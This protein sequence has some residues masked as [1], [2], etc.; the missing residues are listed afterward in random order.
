MLLLQEASGDPWLRWFNATM[1]K[2][3]IDENMDKYVDEDGKDHVASGKK[4]QN[5]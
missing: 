1:M 2:N 5:I 4:F 3:Y